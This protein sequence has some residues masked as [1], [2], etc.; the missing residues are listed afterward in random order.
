[1]N[2]TAR[3]QKVTRKEIWLWLIFVAL[4]AAFT[5]WFL[6]Q[7]ALIIFGVSLLCLAKGLF[8]VCKKMPS[9]RVNLWWFTLCLFVAT[10]SVAHAYIDDVVLHHR[11]TAECGDGTY[12]YSDNNRG[13]CSHHGGVEIWHPHV[14]WWKTI[15]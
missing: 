5:G 14:P 15:E 12:S 11:P 10:V 4:V 13:T 9:A 3:E 8:D 7:Q 6:V 1:M 2:G